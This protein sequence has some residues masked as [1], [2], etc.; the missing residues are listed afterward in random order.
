MTPEHF[1]RF[2]GN[3]VDLDADLFALPSRFYLLMVALDASDDA[4]VEELEKTS[5]YKCSEL[6]TSRKYTLYI[7]L[8]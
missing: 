7:E 4:D 6:S 3:G 8:C 5:L 2:A 1:W